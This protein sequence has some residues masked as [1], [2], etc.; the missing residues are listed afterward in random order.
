MK[1]KITY[2]FFACLFILVSCSKDNNEKLSVWVYESGIVPEAEVT[3]AKVTLKESDKYI[4]GYFE[5]SVKNITYQNSPVKTDDITFQINF[6]KNQSD[7]DESPRMAYNVKGN[8]NYVDLINELYKT[9]DTPM[10]DWESYPGKLR[11]NDE[12]FE[13]VVFKKK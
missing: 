10:L 7:D 9:D 8:T 3:S 2:A 12:L 5:L 11:V 6:L 1:N 4:I 13:N